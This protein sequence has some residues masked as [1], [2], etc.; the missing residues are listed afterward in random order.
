MRLR[1]S[2]YVT[3]S[4]HRAKPS[5]GRMAAYPRLAGFTAQSRRARCNGMEAWVVSVCE[6]DVLS[7][8]WSCMLI[9]TTPSISPGVNSRLGG[10]PRI[11]LSLSLFPAVSPSQH[12]CKADFGFGCSVGPAVFPHC[13]AAFAGL[14]PPFQLARGGER[15]PNLPGHLSKKILFSVCFGVGCLFQRSC[16][17][18]WKPD[19]N[20]PVLEQSLS[21]PK[22]LKE[23]IILASV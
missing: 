4:L 18:P 17:D 9:L 21:R 1:C 20:P 14:V 7:R 5:A 8:L 10:F 22:G 2:V 19:P 3:Y 13:R 6:Y 12:L 15:V 16:M 11:S 23:A